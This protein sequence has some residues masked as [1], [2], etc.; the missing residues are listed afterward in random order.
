MSKVKARIEYEITPIRHV[1]I[2]CPS[3]HSWFNAADLTQDILRD[4][5]DVELAEYICGKCGKAF[6]PQTFGGVEI[7]ERGYPSVYENCLE[8][9][10][11]FEKNE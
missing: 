7:E 2:Q 10:V 3:C 4:G 1:A 9:K 5:V 11:V 6:C 8:R